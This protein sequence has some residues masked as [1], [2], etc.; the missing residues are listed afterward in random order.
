MQVLKKLHELILHNSLIYILLGKELNYLIAQHNQ[1]RSLA[2]PR[3]NTSWR[4]AAETIHLKIILDL[5]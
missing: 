2:E 1:K 3:A 4:Y 5:S